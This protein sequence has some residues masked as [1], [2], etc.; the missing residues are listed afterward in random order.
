MAGPIYRRWPRQ[1]RVTLLPRFAVRGLGDVP[2]EILTLIGIG[3]AKS[4]L[5]GW[6][7]EADPAGAPAIWSE[8]R[9]L[10]KLLHPVPSTVGL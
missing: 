3:A 6:E 9:T 4:C 8:E 7:S 10:L 2:R 1:R 5:P